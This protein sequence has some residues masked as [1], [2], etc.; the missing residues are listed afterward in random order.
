[1]LTPDYLETLPDALVELWQQVED[2]ILRDIARRIGKMPDRDTLTDTA[3]WQAWRYEQM[4]ACHQDVLSMLSKYSGKSKAEIRRLL[5]DAGLATLASDDA[6]YQAMGFAPSAIDT[7]QALNNL[8]NAGYRQT[9]GTWQNL[10]AT[11]ANTVTGAFEKRLD[12]AWLQVSSG[13]FDYDTA[14]RRAVENLADQMP[15]V[16]Y[17]SG[18]PRA[19]SLARKDL[20][21]RRSHRIQGRTV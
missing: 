10:T 11:T 19:C 4:Q 8:L 18:P 6:L 14:I 9:L 12:E 21:P 16:T 13:A 17:P 5:L 3:A 1:M 20:P 15:G 7:N 2:D